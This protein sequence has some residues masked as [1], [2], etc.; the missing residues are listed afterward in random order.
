MVPK[1]V[2]HTEAFQMNFQ[3]LKTAEKHKRLA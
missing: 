3:S 2:I 1:L